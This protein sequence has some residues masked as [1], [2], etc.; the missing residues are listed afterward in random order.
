MAEAAMVVPR[1][2]PSPSTAAARPSA[3]SVLPYDRVE[4]CD[5]ELR[6]PA[7]S[8]QLPGGPPAD[9]A[10]T[11][12]DYLFLGVR[13]DSAGGDHPAPGHL[14][15]EYAPL[16]SPRSAE[17]GPLLGKPGRE[18]CAERQRGGGGAGRPH[19]SSDCVE[20][21]CYAEMMDD[22][23]RLV[24]GEDT[25]SCGFIAGGIGIS[26]LT[27]GIYAVMKRRLVP[28]GE[29]GLVICS[30]KPRL[31]R[32]GAHYITETDAIFQYLIPMASSRRV[33]P[34]PQDHPVVYIISV[35]E[36]EIGGAYRADGTYVRFETGRH[37]LQSAMYTDPVV[38]SLVEPVVTVG[39]L[40]ILRVDKGCLGGAY[41]ADG[42]F[43]KLDPGKYVLHARDFR[44]VVLIDP[45]Q[46]NKPVVRLGP[47]TVLRVDD[48]TVGAAYDRK[49]V[50]RGFGPGVHTL[51]DQEWRQVQRLEAKDLSK[52]I[53]RLGPL[54][55]LRVDEGTLGGA[56][57]ARG[58]FRKFGPGA[59]YLHDASWR[60]VQRLEAA[61]LNKPLVRLGPL[62]ILRVDD[63]FI[64]GAYKNGHFV[65]FEPPCVQVLH[66][67]EYRDVAIVRRT[68]LKPAQLGPHT[69]VTVQEGF[70]GVAFRDG[71]L[72][73]LQ[74]G[75]HILE[76]REVFQKY[77]SMQQHVDVLRELT[78]TTN[79]G[80]NMTVR[81]VITYQACDA[82]KAA[83]AVEDLK[84]SVHEQAEIVLSRVCR[85]YSREDLM[86]SV[87]TEGDRLEAESER[88]GESLSAVHDKIKHV[89]RQIHEQSMG[90]LSSI[91]S[92]WG[93]HAIS[94]DVESFTIIDK[95]VKA[96]ISSIAL[97]R[98]EAQAA[99]AVRRKELKD[100]EAE[101]KKMQLQA[102]TQAQA[103]RQKAEAE[104]DA[105]LVHARADAQAATLRAEAEAG[106]MKMRGDGEAESMKML[107]EAKAESLR[108]VAAA[109]CAEGGDACM[110][111]QVAQDY[112]REFG[113]VAGKSN[114]MIIP[115]D[116][117]NVGA[118]VARALGISSAV[119]LEH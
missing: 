96:N 7:P 73:I 58:E 103:V 47:L 42:G 50:Y 5:W 61:Q 81:G 71:E 52:A 94:V 105:L 83:V 93:I 88:T 11:M 55:I 38:K 80:I 54:T 69:V 116:P 43:V 107:G 95:A 19:W 39:P 65:L 46:V 60:M 89:Y 12:R 45:S 17:R 41:D 79:D 24:N 86:P 9:A 13:V 84:A 102:Q 119:R 26:V 2:S 28:P 78:I 113:Q 15:C 100:A 106:G 57:D 33:R 14:Q 51:H 21:D 16:V 56:Y 70:R 62:T 68:V 111:M 35:R 97:S 44:D 72:L 117:N 22:L 3:L 92:A 31:L 30:G 115:D 85:S 75:H 36:G 82:E 77:V 118:F 1:A 32:P 34:L 48:G 6:A 37:V 114:T 76:P 53:V 59:Y 108:R 87:S 18:D 40:T 91:F 63:G 109:L 64:G 49:G 23:I 20:R 8:P 10:S 4:G 110:R 99:E 101:A 66:D 90:C 74:P 112:I 67:L 98:I 104:G 25:T 29:L 27:L